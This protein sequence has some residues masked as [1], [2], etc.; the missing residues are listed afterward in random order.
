[1]R[2]PQ[3]TVTNG[4]WHITL[5]VFR[6]LGLAFAAVLLLIYVLVV[7]WFQSFATP[8]VIM[9]GQQ[10]RAMIALEAQLTNVDATQLPRPL[11]KW[12]VEPPR[13]QDVPAALA[14]AIFT[15][16]LPPRGPDSQWDFFSLGGRRRCYFDTSAT[17]CA[18]SL[19]ASSSSGVT[20]ASNDSRMRDS[21]S[22][23][24]PWSR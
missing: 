10:T 1:M 16:M 17:A 23:P 14:R 21:F 9:A 6:D 12:S 24:R 15:A 2:S 20:M 7:G 22:S 8:L 11:V 5:E 13:P 19:P 4:D 18:I 3:A